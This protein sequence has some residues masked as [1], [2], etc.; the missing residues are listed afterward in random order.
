[1]KLVRGTWK[2]LVGIKD[3]LVLLA[4]LLFF[5]L[6]F[7]A[8]SARPNAAAITDGALVIDLAGSL[9]EQPE[10]SDP[11]AS[12]AGGEVVQQHRLRDVV[13]ALDAARTDARV[14]AVVIDMDRFLGGYPAAVS[15]VADA[16]GRVRA[17]GKPVLA[18]ATAYTDDSYLIA[19]NASEVWVDPFGGALFSGPGGTRLYYKG[20]IDRLG[21]NAHIY[22]VGTYKAAVEPFLRNDQ[23][24]ESAE[25]DRALYGTLLARWQ[26]EVARARP[27]AQVRAFLAQPAQIVTAAGGDIA[28]ANLRGGLVDKLGDRTAFGQR[29]AELAGAEANKPAGS[30]KTITMK[31]WLAAN[32]LPTSGDAI[33]I[34]TVAG[35][36]VDGEAGP[37]TAAGDT[38]S[39][40]LYKGLAE[41]DLKALVVRVDSPGGS[42]LASEKIRQ[43]ILAAKGRGIPVVVS[44]GSLAA[45][46]GYWVSTPGDVIFAEPETI[47]GSIGVFG[48]LPTFEGTLEKIGVGADGVRT[49]P[50]SGQPD[51]FSG[52]NAA[53]DTILQSNVENNYRRFLS[54]VS[55]SR[56]MPVARVDQVAQGRVWAGGTA[57]QLGLVDR[58]GGIEDAI[59][60]AARRAQLDPQTVRPLYLEK[61]PSFAARVAEMLAASENDESS[62]TAGRDIFARLAAERRGLFAQAI[63]DARRLAAGPAL[64]AR[65]VECQAFGP[66]AGSA[67]DARIARYL[68]ERSLP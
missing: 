1:M 62:D 13:R 17:A 14:K 3:G 32:P 11:F 42:V 27:K 57:R 30:F 22:R 46:G 6:L 37:G 36:I 66:A 40:L 2:L 7:A 38:L 45:S 39:D 12:L 29:V 56:K 48:I 65:C 67:A 31:N 58:F 49:T 64:Q 19:A 20:L 47:T 52:T 51:L 50:L 68:I 10:Q 16:V 35:E 53:V 43:A 63:G 8:L 9:V 18:F 26:E 5:G 34:L 4:M 54:V 60:E 61:P 21:V 55:Q 25:A 24:P 33:G 44:M 15:T 28:Q 23:S 41:Q 59:A